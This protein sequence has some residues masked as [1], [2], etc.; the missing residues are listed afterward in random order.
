MSGLQRRVP[1]AGET[2]GGKY[3]L[4]RILGEGGMGTVF[5]AEH[6]RLR[7]A[8]AIK[9]LNPSMLGVEEIVK[10]FEREARAAATLKSRHVVRVMDVEATPDGIPYM[11]MELLGG[12]DLEGLRAVRPKLPYEEVVDYI[13]QACDAL[14]E[15]HDA[16]IVHRD[17]KPGHVM[18][19]QTRA[20]EDFVKVLDFGRSTGP[21]GSTSA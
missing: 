20:G 5:E 1:E 3:L 13:L 14:A 2:L 17:R 18:L 12:Q 19:M 10:R 11:V 9:C 16:G 6:L 7:Q 8:C 21:T 4:K 15:A